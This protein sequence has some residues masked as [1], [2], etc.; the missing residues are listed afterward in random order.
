MNM[1]FM[2]DENGKRRGG[3]F[4]FPFAECVASSGLLV[5][6]A[7]VV[8]AIAASDPRILLPGFTFAA[9]LG[10]AYM[11][12]RHLRSVRSGSTEMVD[13]AAMEQAFQMDVHP[14][15]ESGWEDDLAE[16]SPEWVDMTSATF[17]KVVGT[18]G[19]CPRGLTEGDFLKAGADGSIA[20]ALCAEAEAVLR[21]AAGVDI[22][23]KEWCCPIYDHLLVFE[24][25]E[26]LTKQ[27]D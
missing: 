8:V 25:Q 15:F 13:A 14:L 26:K 10:V 16:D 22:D 5:A 1:I 12:Y 23:V 2:W 3:R 11:F 19:I 4:N 9:I 24:K 7:S 6:A 17:F 18:R 21:M 20:P 27:A